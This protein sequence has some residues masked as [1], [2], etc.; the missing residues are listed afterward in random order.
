MKVHCGERAFLYIYMTFLPSSRCWM[1]GVMNAF[2]HVVQLL[3]ARKLFTQS[4]T[5]MW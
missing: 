3:W 4:V 5:A 2:R 1:V